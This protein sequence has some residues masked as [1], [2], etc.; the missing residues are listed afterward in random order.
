MPWNLT[1]YRFHSSLVVLSLTWASVFIADVQPAVAQSTDESL[2]TASVI[3]PEQKAL[4]QVVEQP[5]QI[6]PYEMTP[7]HAK[8][9]GYVQRI[10]VDLGDTI[11]GPKLDKQG[12]V[13][14]PGQVLA[15]IA[16]PELVAE[17][18]QKRSVLAQ[19]R[20]EVEQAKAG[21]QVAESKTLTAQAAIAAAKA[22]MRRSDALVAKTASELKRITELNE[23]NA[24][25]TKLVDETRQSAEGAQ[26]DRESA[27]A[28]YDAAQA[29]V[30]ESQALVNKAR[31]DLVA[32][33]ARVQV[34]EAV[35]QETQVKVDYATLRAPFTGVVTRRNA[36]TGHLVSAG[37]SGEPLLALARTDIVRVFI[38]VPES[39][40]SR[41]AVGNPVSLRFPATSLDPLT[42]KVTRMSWSLDQA[43]RTIRAEVEI[44]NPD[45]RYRAGSYVHAALVVGE[46][47]DARVLP[48]TALTFDKTQTFCLIVVDGKV[49]RR[50]VKLGLRTAT[51][52]EIVEGLTS[53]EQVIRANAAI[54]TP[55]Q[56]VRPVVFQPPKL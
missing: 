10:V 26:A 22:A 54:Y 33:E 31:A 53:D 56:A 42:V 4:K 44:P 28:Q 45:G 25:A 14:T 13:T 50:E 39:A 51:E 30:G 49:V 47:A 2:V 52:A 1:M 24:V 17:L 8:V 7:L 48:L 43:T 27:A 55:G 16:V 12:K 36:H 46:K 34:A 11:Q 19:S 18:Q 35:V 41:V 23:R 6:E 38:D 32:A 9:S 3:K 40:A 21:V 5:A 37:A 20:A 29:A 15:E